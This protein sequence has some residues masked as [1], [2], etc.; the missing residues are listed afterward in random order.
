MATITIGG[1]TGKSAVLTDEIE[2]QATG[3]GASNKVTLTSVASAIT[4]LANLTSIQGQTV[5]LTGAFVRSGAHS[6]TLTTTGAT[7]V[8]L[9]TTGTLAVLASPAFTGTPTAPT[10]A[11]ATN[12][13]QLAT[14]AH[15]FAERTNAATLTN[16]TLTS[17]VLTTPAL[18][19]PASGALTNCTSIPVAQATGNLPVANLGSGTGATSSTYW[20]GDG[21]WA[22]PAGGGNVSNS[23]TPTGGQMAVWTS[24]TQIQGVSLGSGIQTWLTTPSS[25]NLR[26]AM[27][28]EAGDGALVFA[29]AP[30][31]LSTGTTLNKGTHG[32]R[33]LICDTAATH[34]VDDD[35]G[36]SWAA[37]DVLYGVN[38]SA[39]NVVLQGDGTSAVT[40]GAGQSLTVY[41]GQEWAL[42]RTGTNAWRGGATAPEVLIIPIGD[43]TT[44]ITTGTAKVTFR[45]PYAG[46]LVAV[47]ASL[48]TASSSGTP[49]FD[50]N[51]GGTTMLSTKLTVDASELT[52]TTAAAAAVISDATFA[53]DAVGT[54]DIDTAG[55][56]AAGA[57]VMLYMVRGS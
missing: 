26:A 18:G 57:K 32:N 21:T 50:L 3:G 40:A 49:T 43:E 17:P 14:T 54:I 31:T 34:S 12:T 47:R 6:L 7:N 25:A 5:T 1:L 35:T 36:G 13:T 48:T 51:E 33:L 23:G 11:A 39:G 44:A 52:S 22:T 16:K 8:T 9:P 38:T 53:D 46:R 24:S 19:T 37:G 15:V 4:T 20:R 56:G 41:P 28:D 2:V 27:T 29:S 30:A 45:F 10:A 42:Q 55:T